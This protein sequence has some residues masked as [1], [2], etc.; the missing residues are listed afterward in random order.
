ML[1]FII[2]EY[3]IQALTCNLQPVTFNLVYMQKDFQKIVGRFISYLFRGVIVIAPI[4]VTVFIL[5]KI[6]STVDGTV[7]DLIEGITGHR[8]PAL[9]LLVGIVFIAFIGAISSLFLLRPL[10]RIFEEVITHTPLVKIIYSSIKD[11]ISAFVGNNKK[12]SQ[13]ILVS[14]NGNPRFQR[15]GFLT[16]RDF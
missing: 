12:F 7:N 4:S 8:Y 14:I 11:L 5:Y 2:A 16:E 3:N 13:P 10:F 15:L 1:N 9:G 6:V